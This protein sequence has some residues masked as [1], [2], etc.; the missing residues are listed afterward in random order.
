MLGDYFNVDTRNVHA[1]ILG[2]HGDSEFPCLCRSSIHLS[3][4]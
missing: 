3:V 2:E 4:L 1:Y